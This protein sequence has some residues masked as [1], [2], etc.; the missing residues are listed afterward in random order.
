MKDS[1]LYLPVLKI[2]GRKCVVTLD[3]PIATVQRKRKKIKME[4]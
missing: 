3:D 2:Q 1:E 4:N